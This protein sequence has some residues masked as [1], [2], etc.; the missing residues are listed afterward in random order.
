MQSTLGRV[1]QR[2]NVPAIHDLAKVTPRMAVQ[3]ADLRTL[4]LLGY[5]AILGGSNASLAFA[6]NQDQI[7]TNDFRRV[8]NNFLTQ[9]ELPRGAIVSHHD[10]MPLLVALEAEGMVLDRQALLKMIPSDKSTLIRLLRTNSGRKFINQT[11][12]NRLMFDRLDRITSEPGGERMLRDLMK[13][14]DAARYA[15]I[16]T[17]PGVPDMIDF[18]P[19]VR[20]SKTRRVKDYKKPTGKLYTLDDVINHL[21]KLVNQ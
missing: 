17:G 20:S 16:D 1:S 13:L 2:N 4:L 7:S 11:S 14:P 19:K 6:Q 12:R 15:K 3:I 8:V 9:H 5:L 10:V 21:A 18:L